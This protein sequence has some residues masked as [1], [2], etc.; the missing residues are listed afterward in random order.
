LSYTTLL[1]VC[2]DKDKLSILVQTCSVFMQ[3]PPPPEHRFITDKSIL[4]VHTVSQMNPTYTFQR[5]IIVC[6]HL[7]EPPT[8]NQ[9]LVNQRGSRQ[10]QRRP[11]TT[12]LR[13]ASLGTIRC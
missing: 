7:W 4:L 13:H 6:I 1:Y 2:R 3:P 9:A 8:L 10:L 5:H 11:A 12:Y